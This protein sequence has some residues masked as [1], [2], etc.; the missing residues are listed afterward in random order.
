[1]FFASTRGAEHRR[2]RGHFC[3]SQG[4][5][6]ADMARRRI[7]AAMTFAALA[8]LMFSLAWSAAAQS[9][10]L[11]PDPSVISKLRE[12][13]SQ[14]SHI[15]EVMGFLTDVYGPRLTNSPNIREAGDYAVK[16]LGSWG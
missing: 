7:R 9:E 11:A 16:T 5:I 6:G 1:M 3:R 14:H 13:E 2:D 12:E 15:M 4:R 8:T 10:W